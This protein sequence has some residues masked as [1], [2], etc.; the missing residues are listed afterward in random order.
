MI[1][2][3]PVLLLSISVLCCTRSDSARGWR[4]INAMKLAID[5]AASPGQRYAFRQHYADALTQFVEANPDHHAA[6]RAYAEACLGLARELVAIGR[7][8]ESLPYFHHSI[9]HAPSAEARA[10]LKHA[11]EHRR[12]DHD[13]LGTATLG[14]SSDE[15]KRRLGTPRPGWRKQAGTSGGESWYYTAES[16]GL[17]TVFLVDGKVVSTD[18][19]ASHEVAE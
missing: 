13:E 9:A 8:E 7:I 4:E 3:F 18:Y 19:G 16:G 11:M 14:M 1:A 2:P 6:K 12:I 10:E 15:V 17:A 5:G